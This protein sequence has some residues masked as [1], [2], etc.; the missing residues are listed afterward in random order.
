MPGIT[1]NVSWVIFIILFIS[2]L[3]FCLGVTHFLQQKALR[4]S[5]VSKIQ[6][7]GE[8]IDVDASS[9]ESIATK[10][11]ASFLRPFARIGA[12]SPAL[13]RSQ[14]HT[15]QRLKFLRAG[16]RDDSAPAVYWGLKILLTILLPAA[17]IVLKLTVLG[18][19]SQQATI[20]AFVC[21]ALL[22]FY[23][24]DIWLKQKSDKRKQKILES[25]PDALD[26]LVICVEAGMGLDSAI[27]R[28]AQEIRLSCQE[29]SDELQFMNLE[30]RAGK[31]RQ[32]ALRSLALRTNLDEINSLAT[33]LIQTDKFGTSMADALRIYADTY[34]TE[35]YQKA[36]ELAAKLPVKLLFPLVAFIFP[37]LFVVLLGP[38]AI[39]IYKALLAG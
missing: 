4:R 16:I 32:E 18:L 27:S 26:L 11:S 34:R 29:L 19:L 20:V 15:A 39:S 37:A 35:R 25:L 13:V 38:A 7:S 30:L 1:P 10:P 24:P 22:G 23:I 33:L 17:F 2:L 9:E 28:V 3:L 36:E 5:L 21:C 12:I 14:E 6:G 8:R 31:Q